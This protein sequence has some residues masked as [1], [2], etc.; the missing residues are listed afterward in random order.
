[1]HWD[2]LLSPHRRQNIH[3]NLL[4]GSILFAAALTYLS[5][6][7]SRR[8]KQVSALSAW[9]RTKIWTIVFAHFFLLLQTM[10]WMFIYPQHLDVIFIGYTLVRTLSYVWTK[11]ECM[12][13]Y[14]E[15]RILDPTYTLGSNAFD[16][17]YVAMLPAPLQWAFVIALLTL[18]PY[19][20][21]VTFASVRVPLPDQIKYALIG[22]FL[23][24]VYLGFFKFAGKKVTSLLS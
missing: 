11:G 14:A 8:A 23:G 24:M 12:I 15:K 6:A 4:V 1:M 9:P 7:I 13:N 10:M 18:M 2:W 20:I 22:A 16:E 5:L 17:P 3:W 21:W 19:M